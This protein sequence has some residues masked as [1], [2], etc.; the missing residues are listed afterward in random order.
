MQVKLFHSPCALIS[1][2]CGLLAHDVDPVEVLVVSG[3]GCNDSRGGDGWLGDHVVR[4][5]PI[6]LLLL[7][8]GHAGLLYAVGDADVDTV[9]WETTVDFSKHLVSVRSGSITAKDGVEGALVNDC[10]KSTVFITKRSHVHLF[11]RHVGVLV[12][13]ELLHLL[14]HSEWNVDVGDVGVAVVIHLFRKTCKMKLG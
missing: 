10:I 2:F 14:D 7:E 12:F 11:V 8:V 9:G 13:V 3:L 1:S 6:E 5:G 4:N